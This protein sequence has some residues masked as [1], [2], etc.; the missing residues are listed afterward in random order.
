MASFR[1]PFQSDAESRDWNASLFRYLQ[2]PSLW[3]TLFFA[4][5]ALILSA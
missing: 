4:L 1:L 5:L 3:A 2:S